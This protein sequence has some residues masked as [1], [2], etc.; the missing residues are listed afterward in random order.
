MS[1]ICSPSHDLISRLR[2]SPEQYQEI[3]AQFS[4][5]DKDKSGAIDTKELRACL[6][7]LNDD[8]TKAEVAKIMEEFGVQ[9]GKER[10]M[11][12]EGFKEFMIRQ[13]GDSDTADEVGSFRSPP[14]LEFA[15]VRCSCCTASSWSAV[16][17]PLARTRGATRCS[18]SRKSPTW[19][20]RRPR[21]AAT[22]TTSPG[23]RLRLLAKSRF[24]C[25]ATG[26]R[27]RCRH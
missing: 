23:S 6:Y 27:L 26:M 10:V 1:A 19:P 11:K 17:C 14:P 18:R 20:R 25:C 12:Y 21:P 8:R 15:V 16:A 7:S 13:L 9:E 22:P 5:F 3:K 2:N 24:A 4:Q